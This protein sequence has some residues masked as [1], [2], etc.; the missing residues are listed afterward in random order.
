M[1]ESKEEVKWYRKP[2]PKPDLY[3]VVCRYLADLR[4]NDD[5]HGINIEIMIQSSILNISVN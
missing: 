5:Y 1:K 4:E 2:V 3:Q